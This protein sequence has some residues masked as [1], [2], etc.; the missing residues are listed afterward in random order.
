MALT[1]TPL[2]KNIKYLGSF[3]KNNL[4]KLG[5]QYSR[6]YSTKSVNKELNKLK[7]TELVSI[8]NSEDLSFKLWILNNKPAKFYLNTAKDKLSIFNDNNSKSGIYLWLNNENDKYYIGSAINLKNRLYIYYN[9]QKL[10]NENYRIQ[11]AIIKYTHSKFSL[12]ILEYCDIKD[13]IKR[14]QYYIDLLTPPYN[15][16]QTAG[17]RLGKE[18]NEESLVK[19]S[20]A[21]VGEKNPMYGINHS[22]ITKA[23]MNVNKIGIPL[24]DAHKAK[25]SLA[26]IGIPISEAARLKRL[27]PV[28]LYS[29]ENPT[30][31]YKFFNSYSETAKYLNCSNSVI[32]RY[33]NTNKV[34]IKKWILFSNKLEN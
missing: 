8:M 12:Y 27:K 20:E 17:S 21:K 22:E 32:T 2:N 18:H 7:D 16:L 28:Y 3:K 4:I 31:L 34:F 24:T 13:L 9:S 26:K 25:L 10:I 5:L 30:I 14:E 19:M 33:I 23:T 6:S 29:S 11:R 15:I 1:N